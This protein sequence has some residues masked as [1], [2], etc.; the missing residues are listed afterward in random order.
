MTLFLNISKLLHNFSVIRKNSIH[1]MLKTELKVLQHDIN[2]MSS[3]SI[4]I[5]KTN[6]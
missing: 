2:I 5:L 4:K 1:G 3:K 6:K